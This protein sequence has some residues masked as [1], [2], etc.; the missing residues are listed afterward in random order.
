MVHI[1]RLN[2]ELLSAFILG[3]F[4]YF[5]FA[6]RVSKTLHKM[7]KL[8]LTQSRVVLGVIDPPEGQSFDRKKLFSFFVANFIQLF[9]DARVSEIREIGG[10]GRDRVR[11]EQNRIWRQSSEYFTSL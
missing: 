10:S 9:F 3:T 4:G 8:K 7:T 11:E 2:S 1:S 6:I 5:Y